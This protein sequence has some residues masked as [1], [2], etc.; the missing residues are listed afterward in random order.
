EFLTLCTNGLVVSSHHLDR[1]RTLL[2]SALREMES[3]LPERTGE[4]PMLIRA[5]AI[6]EGEHSLAAIAPADLF[7]VDAMIG[8]P[9]V[10]ATGAALGVVGESRQ[11]VNLLPPSMVQTAAGFGIRELALSGAVAV[12][13]L[14]L[15]GSITAKNLS[16]HGALASEVDD[17]EPRVEQALKREEKN[18]E[19]LATVERLESKSR[20]RVLTYLK[21]ITELVP[22]T[23]YLTTFRFREDKVEVDGIAEKASDLIAILE[24][25]PYF[26]GVEFTA[27]T[28]KYLTNQERFSLRMRIEQ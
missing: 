22:A 26:T 27:P 5:R 8:E 16:I 2:E 21:A 19:M 25:S 1:R 10:I 14:L 4:T 11:N 20:S 3:S 17:L 6:E 7:P 15:L 13:G 18:S 9:E 23:A 12:M 28:T 24:S